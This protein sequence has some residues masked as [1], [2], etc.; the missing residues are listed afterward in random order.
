MA[1]ESEHDHPAGPPSCIT[2]ISDEVWEIPTSYKKGMLVPARIFATKKLLDQMDA[3][4]F[5]Q[6]TNVACLPGIKN[7]AYCMP[8]G[9]WGYGFPIGGVAAFD[10]ENGII[11]PGGIGFDINCGVR[12]VRTNL[13]LEEVQ[14]K[15]KELV[16]HLFERVPCGVGCKGFIKPTK[17]EFKEL[18]TRGAVWAVEHGFGWKEDIERIEENGCIKSA[19]A[20]KITDRA[21]ARGYEQIG[22]LGSGNHYLEIQYVK[23][24]FDKKV[25]EKFGITNENQICVMIH[26]GSRGFGHQVATDYL[27][28]FADAMPRYGITIPDRELA[29]APFKTKEGQDYYAAMAC[30]ANLAFCNRQVI[31]HRVRECFSKVFGKSAEELGMH[32]VYDVAHNIAKL[33]DHIIDGKKTKLL[34]H[35]KGATRCFG[36]GREEI[37]ELYRKVGQPVLIG[38][39]METGS[40]ILVGTKKAEQETFGSTCHGAGRTMS[41]AKAKKTVRGEQLQKDMEKHG[42]YVK[43]VSMSGLAEEAG[44]AYK[45]ISDVIE[46]MHESGVST[47]VALLKPIGNVKG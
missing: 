18:V 15:I 4:V 28:I 45:N 29:C 13:T 40:Y 21:I 24:I 38:G 12:V 20:S 1:P 16:N 41:R 42:I 9:H 26:C 31:M 34:V 2:K 5:D 22:T 11:S 30:A 43:A 35:R 10:P 8:D 47:K 14:P 37:P 39:S 44:L 27:K 17:E 33:E 32:L 6:V 23:E 36:P 3:G 7:Y 19:D 46:T 25:A